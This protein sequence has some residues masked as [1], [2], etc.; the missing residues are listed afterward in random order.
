[1]KHKIITSSLLS[2]LCF[3]S[4]SLRAEEIPS[5][6][7]TGTYGICNCTKGTDK[8]NLI[9][10]SLNQDLSFSYTDRSDP[11]RPLQVNGTYT[12]QGN[13]VTLVPAQKTESFHQKWK[14][15]KEGKCI[16]SRHK[17]NF[18]RICLL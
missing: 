13:K 3:F 18:R 6:K 17:L 7:N 15:E 16:T 14:F 2:I 11:K 5:S 12:T 4:F 1:M 8:T 9:E 10:L